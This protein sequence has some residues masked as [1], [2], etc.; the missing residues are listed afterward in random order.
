MSPESESKPCLS[1]LETYSLDAR[2]RI[3]LF[4]KH[5]NWSQLL[6]VL[7]SDSGIWENLGIGIVIN[8][9]GIE[10]GIRINDN[11]GQVVLDI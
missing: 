5:W 10:I 8:T 9:A 1:E 4:G 7:E 3:K 6:L 11:S 2:I